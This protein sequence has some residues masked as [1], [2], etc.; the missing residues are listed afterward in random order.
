MNVSVHVG[1]H[2]C[3]CVR[4]SIL[5][6]EGSPSIKLKRTHQA[7]ANTML[8]SQKLGSKNCIYKDVCFVSCDT[9][10]FHKSFPQ[11]SEADAL[12]C[13]S[14]APWCSAQPSAIDSNFHALTFQGARYDY[15]SAL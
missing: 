3:T 7:S 9:C 13:F 2:G 12:C 11:R 6:W 14:S 4:S 8:L 15:R 1:M 10:M 5:R